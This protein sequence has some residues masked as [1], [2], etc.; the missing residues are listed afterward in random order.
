MAMRKKGWIAFV[1]VA[2]LCASLL[3]GCGAVQASK[4]AQAM[5]G[6]YYTAFTD[7]DGKAVLSTMHDSLVEDL[8][9]EEAA[10]TRLMAR[11]ALLGEVEDY[12]V[13]NTSVSTKDGDSEV[14]L[15]VDTEYS[16]GGTM[17]ETYTFLT[18]DDGLLMTG[19]N[20]PREA[21][22]DEVA[23]A[24]FAALGDTE[25]MSALYIP[26][27]NGSEL[28]QDLS[29]LSERLLK[30]CGEYTAY[31]LE[32]EQFYSRSLGD[33]EATFV[34]AGYYT[35]TCSEMDALCMLQMSVEN[36]KLGLNNIEITPAPA[37][38]LCE[39]YY[40]AM[41][42]KDV[43]TAAGLYAQMFYDETSGGRSAWIDEV[44]TPLCGTYGAFV[45]YDIDE[46]DVQETQ[47]PDGT[48]TNAIWL[49]VYSEYEDLSLEEYFLVGDSGSGY[50]IL[51]HQ[52]E[53]T[54]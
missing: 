29:S 22:V 8:G 38:R 17:E 20:L 4:D 41:E 35:V 45:S 28:E 2:A 18:V 40:D 50:E 48:V 54:G 34:Y 14:V 33:S 21:G 42:Q 32:N 49:H 19:I 11:R 47:L 3:C 31:T 23:A 24:A 7:G 1:V 36:G 15:T 5:L 26:L 30:A 51:A 25:A 37:Y 13:T 9:G 10:Q 44:L 6:Q 43:Q 53:K 12:N 16:V 27:L 52:L 46:W 39:A